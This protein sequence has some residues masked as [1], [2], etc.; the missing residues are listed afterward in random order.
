MFPLLQLHKKDL[1][2]VKVTLTEGS[3]WEVLHEMGKEKQIFFLSFLF[4]LN[5]LVLFPHFLITIRL[6]RVF[7]L[8]EYGE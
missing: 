8:Y 5:I 3:Y 6:I 7:S 1:L 4:L 2:E